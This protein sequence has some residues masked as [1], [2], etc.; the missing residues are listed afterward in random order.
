MCIYIVQVS[1]VSSRPNRPY[2]D[3]VQSKNICQIKNKVIFI[4]ADAF[5]QFYSTAVTVKV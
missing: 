2:H 5:F 1:C 4:W 3:R